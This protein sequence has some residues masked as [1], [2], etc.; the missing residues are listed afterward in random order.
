MATQATNSTASTST[1]TTYGDMIKKAQVAPQLGLN[2][3]DPFDIVSEN[4]Q[5]TMVHY[6]SD[7]DPETYGN[8]RG[9]VVDKTTGLMVASSYPHTPAIVSPY[10][11]LSDG[12]IS[13]GEWSFPETELRFK[14]GSEGTLIHVYKHAGQVYRS[15]RKRLDPAK[16]RWGNS[17]TFGEMYWALGGP[18]DSQLFDSEKDYSPYCHS[19]IMVHPDV[20]VVS[21]EDD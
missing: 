15:T 21:K 1:S 13:F 8:L 19:F 3:S 6:R 2:P 12:N 17:K 7:A 9:V 10:L 11:S 14:I 4:E 16:S 5:L 18:T 20:L